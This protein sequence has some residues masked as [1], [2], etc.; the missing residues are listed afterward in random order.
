MKALLILILVLNLSACGLSRVFSG[1]TEQVLAQTATGD[2]AYNKVGL[3]I[4]L[5]KTQS[6]AAAISDNAEEALKAVAAVEV[7]RLDLEIAEAQ[8]R[9]VIA[10]YTLSEEVLIEMQATP[11]TAYLTNAAQCQREQRYTDVISMLGGVVAQL[12]VRESDLAAV[13]RS[14]GLTIRSVASE[15]TKKL[16]GVVNP[17]TVSLNIGQREST[18]RRNGESFALSTKYA[19]ENA[20]DVT[21]N[22]ST[23][24][25]TSSDGNTGGLAGDAGAGGSGSGTATGGTNG[26]TSYNIGRGISDTDTS[27]TAQALV[28]SDGSQLLSPGARG[29]VNNSSNIDQQPIIEDQNSDLNNSPRN[30]SDNSLF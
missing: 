25:T 28:D 8:N 16:L 6:Q 20:G 24:Q 2:I 23:V 12:S 9:V 3:P 17:L 14:F 7:K 26:D 29:A 13:A 10:C 11:K 18:A 22:I 15:G 1:N 5:N 4:K 27:D 19:A 30:G 21:A